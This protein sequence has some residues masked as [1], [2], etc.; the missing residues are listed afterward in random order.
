MNK[1]YC[2]VCGKEVSEDCDYILIDSISY[3]IC[4]KCKRDTLNYLK[5]KIKLN[6]NGG[7]NGK[8]N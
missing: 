6:N 8:V 3:N 2:D 4:L 7:K 1:T 5:R